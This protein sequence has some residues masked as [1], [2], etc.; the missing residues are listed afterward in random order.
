MKTITINQNEIPVF[1]TVE[2]ADQYFAEKFG[3]ESWASETEE[4]KKKAIVTATRKLNKLKL[5]G[6]PVDFNQPLAFPRYFKPNFLS[7]RTYTAEAKALTIRG[8][9]Y[10]YI[11]ESEDM[12]MACCEEAASIMQSTENSVHIK[13]QKLGIASATIMGD[14]VA[15]TGNAASIGSTVES[16]CPEALQFIDKFLMK[17]ARVV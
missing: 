16:V 6:F 14:S 2:D 5:K 17:T 1:C 15:Y 13:N 11:E 10:I 9:D 3:G 7:K 12:M 8:K 4:N